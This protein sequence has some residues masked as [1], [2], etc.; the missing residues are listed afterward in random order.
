[1]F[2]LM[3]WCVHKFYLGEKWCLLTN[4]DCILFIRNGVIK[5]G[6]RFTILDLSYHISLSLYISFCHRVKMVTDFPLH[7]DVCT[8]GAKMLSC[9]PYLHWNVL[10]VSVSTRGRYMKRK[11]KHS[12]RW[13]HV[14]RIISVKLYVDYVK[15]VHLFPIVLFS[16]FQE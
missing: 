8:V 4:R 1:M 11:I 10:L 7:T 5:N 15:V 6:V 16:Y 9:C 12:G 2:P 14:S 3:S 13:C